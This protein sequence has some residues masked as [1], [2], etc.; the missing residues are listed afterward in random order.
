[1]ETLVS[2]YQALNTLSSLLEN[3]SLHLA[4]YRLLG[5]LLKRLKGDS[6]LPISTV[7]IGR[8]IGLDR[9]SISASLGRLE[10]AKII[11]RGSKIGRLFTYRLIWS[12]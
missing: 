5:E 2:H 3:E 7:E 12:L 4:D 11:S 10:E 6:F 1:M 9:T 8:E